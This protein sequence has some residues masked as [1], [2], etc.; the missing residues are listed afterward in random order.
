[1]VAAATP[2]TATPITARL[3]PVVWITDPAEADRLLG[4]ESRHLLDEVLENFRQAAPEYGWPLTQIEIDYHQDMEFEWWEYLLLTL[5]YDC[6]RPEALEHWKAGMMTVV[7]SM[8]DQLVQP[9]WDLFVER[10]SYVHAGCP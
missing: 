9:A 2:I 10:I 5:R 8:Q 3:I 4:E 7:K 1:M 6:P